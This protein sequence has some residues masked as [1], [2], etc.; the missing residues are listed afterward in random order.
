MPLRG[1]KGTHYIFINSAIKYTVAI[2]IIN[3]SLRLLAHLIQFDF[4]LNARITSTFNFI[5]NIRK[6]LE[7]INKYRVALLLL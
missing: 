1:C 5:E 3:N 7:V 4:I 2:S 6:M